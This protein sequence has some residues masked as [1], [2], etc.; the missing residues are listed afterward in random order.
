[1]LIEEAE[2]VLGVLGLVKYRVLFATM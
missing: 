2:R 1:L